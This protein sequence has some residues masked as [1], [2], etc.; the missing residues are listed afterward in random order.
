MNQG[1]LYLLDNGAK[2][3]I[4]ALVVAPIDESYIGWQRGQATKAMMYG[5]PNPQKMDDCHA[6]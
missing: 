2:N 5:N 3:V 4:T 6:S 1:N